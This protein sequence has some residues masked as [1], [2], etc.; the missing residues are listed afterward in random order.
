MIARA[1]IHHPKILIL[2]EPTAG[3]D[4]ELRHEMWVYLKQL[5]QQGITIILTTHYIEEVEQMC[6]Q[7]VIIKEGEIIHKDYVRNLVKLL[8]KES[9]VITVQDM[10]DL[11]VIKEYQPRVVEKNVIEIELNREQKLNDCILRLIE[12]RWVIA[13]MHPKGRRL[14]QLFLKILKE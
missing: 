9:Y 10:K 3:V 2:D 1:L 6:N 13:D 5:N 8:D 11:N 4:V 7:A 14:E 12:A